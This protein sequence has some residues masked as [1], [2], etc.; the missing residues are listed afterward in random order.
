[1]EQ[2][3]QWPV[4]MFCGQRHLGPPCTDGLVVCCLCYERF[5]VDQL[6]V[7]PSGD[8]EDVCRACAMEE[9]AMMNISRTGPQ[10]QSVT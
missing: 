1:M 5:P 6:H 7:L 9:E 2:E 8:V 4:C 3:I 10:A